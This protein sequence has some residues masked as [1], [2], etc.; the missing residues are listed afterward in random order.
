MSNEQTTQAVKYIGD[1]HGDMS[2]VRGDA[3]FMYLSYFALSMK[4][5]HTGV[6]K[7]FPF[8]NEIVTIDINQSNPKIGRAVQSDKT[9]I[10]YIVNYIQQEFKKTGQRPSREM[11]MKK[12]TLLSSLDYPLMVNLTDA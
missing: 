12:E 8:E 11:V 5:K 3:S 6:E 7:K 4:D 2:S 1:L 9:L 10:W